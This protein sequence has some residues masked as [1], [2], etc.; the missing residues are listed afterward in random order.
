M[1][2][3]SDENSQLKLIDFGFSKQFEKNEDKILYSL[4]GSPLYL[5][6]EVISGSYDIKCDIWSLG[7][8][9]HSMLMGDTP[10]GI[11]NSD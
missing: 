6:P 3:N 4:L 5:A 11:F 9:F 7:I 10:Y 1:L 2:E 8:T